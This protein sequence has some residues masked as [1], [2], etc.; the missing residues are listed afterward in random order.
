MKR[1]VVAC[2][3]A[4]GQGSHTHRGLE[5]NSTEEPP[6]EPVVAVTE[7][8]QGLASLLYENIALDT[9]YF[10]ELPGSQEDLDNWQLYRK[11]SQKNLSE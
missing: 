6:Q 4:L 11:Y 9:Y 5:G 10:G 1:F 3:L 8:E 7:Q 2:L